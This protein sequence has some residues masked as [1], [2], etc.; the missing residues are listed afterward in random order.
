[1][2]V[3][4][5]HSICDRRGVGQFLKGLAKIARG[6]VKPSLEPV[7]NR[8]LLKP[9]DPINLQFYHFE[10]IMESVHSPHQ[11]LLK[12][13]LVQASLFIKNDV[14]KCIKKYFKK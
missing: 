1:M 11:P 10:T 12:E 2:G 5:H 7:W 3:I 6:E 4:F 13:D 8:E 9:K 14:I